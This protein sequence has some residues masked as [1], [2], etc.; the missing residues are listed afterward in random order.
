MRQS[1]RK[2]EIIDKPHF[3]VRVINVH[4][5]AE[6]GN[7]HIA[8]FTWRSDAEAFVKMQEIYSET[9]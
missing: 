7:Y 2:L 4:G 1:K 9:V 3:G 8:D 6:L 5:E